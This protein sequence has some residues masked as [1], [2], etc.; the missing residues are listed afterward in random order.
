CAARAVQEGHADI[1]LML[2]TMGEA[3]MA[4][5]KAGLCGFKPSWGRVSRFGLLGLAPSMEC[6]SLLARNPNDLAQA[7]RTIEGMDDCDPSMVAVGEA[8]DRP[9][10]GSPSKDL[11]AGI[12]TPLLEALSPQERN[13]FSRAIANLQ[14]A[15]VTIREVT[16]KDQGL[17]SVVHQVIASVE[18]SSSCGKYDGVRFGHR[19]QGAK[20]WNEMY[21]ETRRESFSSLLK[22]FL[23]QGAY[24]QFENYPA[25]ENACRIRA[26]LVQENRKLFESLDLMLLP[27][28]STLHDAN[29]ARTLE[30]LYN[31]FPF[32]L[33]ANVTG[34]PALSLP[35]VFKCGGQDMGL[36]VLGP[37][38]G[39]EE[40]LSWAQTLMVQGE[41]AA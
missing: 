6:C 20:N 29:Q 10:N 21:L 17:F 28:Q 14:D 35:S 18:A 4:A 31:A 38:L 13:A 9:G 2:D 22:A 36:Q 24:F 33:L 26:R 11:T 30:Q 39:D 25:F 32:T 40:L 3:R 41:E 1:V 19:A 16:F 37:F 23:F 7:F 12:V 5:A 27:M 15:G 8:R 34:Q